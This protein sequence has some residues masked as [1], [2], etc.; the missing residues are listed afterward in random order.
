M[1][2]TI[3]GTELAMTPAA[4]S[5]A[6]VHFANDLLGNGRLARSPLDI[7]RQIES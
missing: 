3:R 1:T 5:V 2:R 4:I 6:G 7:L